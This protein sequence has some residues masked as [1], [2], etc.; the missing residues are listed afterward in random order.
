MFNSTVESDN[1]TEEAWQ[2]GRSGAS[3]GMEGEKK[4]A[5]P[6]MA[7]REGLAR[8]ILNDPKIARDITLMHLMRFVDHI[9]LLLSKHLA[10]SRFL[11]SLV[12]QWVTSN[13]Y[14]GYL[15]TQS[16]RPKDSSF[17][18]PHPLAFPAGSEIK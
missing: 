7:E 18:N 4:G 13:S 8:M 1:C 15:Q 17:H 3:T 10:Q 5:S 16:N 6:L 12:L 2:K 9:D 11:V 14:Y